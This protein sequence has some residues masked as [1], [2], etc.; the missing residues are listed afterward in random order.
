MQEL[1]LDGIT[2]QFNFKDEY[3]GHEFISVKKIV[4]RGKFKKFQ[5]LT[6][7]HGDWEKFREWLWDVLE[8]PE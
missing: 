6:V 5:T 8:N 1:K 2:Y 7:K 3:E 4:D